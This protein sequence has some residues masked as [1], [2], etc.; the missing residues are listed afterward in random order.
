MPEKTL[1][2][3]EHLSRIRTSFRTTPRKVQSRNTVPI[4]LRLLSWIKTKFHV[5]KR[6]FGNEAP[7][8]RL[9]NHMQM[10]K[11]IQIFQMSHNPAG[12]L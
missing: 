12:N 1:S 11:A 2:E 8:D 9:A 5:I 7:M 4:K 10:I 3:W 6:M